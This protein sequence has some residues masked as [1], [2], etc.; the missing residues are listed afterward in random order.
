MIEK[1]EVVKLLSALHPQEYKVELR[2]RFH[3]IMIRE[4][5]GMVEV[6]LGVGIS[7]FAMTGFI[8]GTR[9]MHRRTLYAVECWIVKEEKRLGFASE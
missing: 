2:K 3:G 4:P 1:S 5:R 9:K 7:Y 6:A 8:S